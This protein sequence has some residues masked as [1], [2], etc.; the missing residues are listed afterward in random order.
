M[1]KAVRV[2]H[3]SYKPVSSPDIERLEYV[4]SLLFKKATL[5]ISQK[6]LTKDLVKLSVID[7]SLRDYE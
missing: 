1:A 4:F 7:N 5:T 2:P 6:P 3:L